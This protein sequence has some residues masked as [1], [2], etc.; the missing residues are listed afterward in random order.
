VALAA[1]ESVAVFRQASRARRQLR[2]L[3]LDNDG[4]VLLLH[5]I[6]TRAATAAGIIVYETVIIRECLIA[7][8]AVAELQ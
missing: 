7:A 8:F 6:A 2:P 1:A 3:L 5:L 4:A